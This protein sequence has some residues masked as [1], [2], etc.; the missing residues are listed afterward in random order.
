MET[1]HTKGKWEKVSSITDNIN[2]VSIYAEDGNKKI[3]NVAAYDFY[4]VPLIEAEANAKLIADI[5]LMF[6]YILKKANEGDMEAL[7]IIERHV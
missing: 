6:E 7:K 5:P 1:K 2:T 3:V 4:N